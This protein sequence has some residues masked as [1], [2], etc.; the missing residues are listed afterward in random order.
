MNSKRQNDPFNLSPIWDAVFE[1]YDEFAKICDRHQLR[2][3]VTDGNALGAVRHGGFIP[4]DD[5]LDVS[6]PRPDY[7]RFIEYAK[8]ELPPHLKFVYYENTPE[9][10]WL[11][12]KVQDTRREVVE[13][14]EKKVGHILSNGLFL[15][16]FPIEGYPN[17]GW[18][19]LWEKIKGAF[20]LPLSR[21]RLRTYKTQSKKGKK[22]WLI[23]M[24]MSPFV[25][26]WRSQKSF[27]AF[28]DGQL[29][30]YS[31]DK[32][33]MTGRACSRLNVL[34]RVP[35]PREI[36]GKGKLID[37]D[38]RKVPVP[39]DVHAHLRNE[40]GPNYM[41]PPPADQQHPT[42]GYS[43]RCAWWLGPTGNM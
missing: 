34:K 21:Y 20:L 41:T 7:E 32:C 38:G 28:L 13:A 42:H 25:P 4:W 43:Y 6:M 31:F 16:V 22:A 35:A 11:F 17:P 30:R 9:Y 10:Y 24:L 26:F 33:S 36:W 27:M 8:Q 12:G 29:K 19:T 18:Q 2:Y 23:G 15:D 3:Y 5:D 40:F 39:D 1:I 14:V 37:F